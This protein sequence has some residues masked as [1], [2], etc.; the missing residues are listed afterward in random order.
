[1]NKTALNKQLEAIDLN[2]PAIR[3]ELRKSLAGFALIYLHHYFNLE[4]AD[5]HKELF[6]VIQNPKEEMI[7][8]TGFRGSA[9][10]TLTSFALPLWLALEGKHPFIILLSDS[11]TQM[12]MN[13]QNIKRELEDNP[14]ILADYGMQYSAKRNWSKGQLLLKNDVMLLG[15]ARGMKVRG[16]RW[17]QNRPS[18]LVGDDLESLDWVQKKENRDKT[19]RWFTSEVIPAVQED[20]SKI[21]V[22]GNLLHND[23]LMARLK[24]NKLF[25]CLDYPL[26]KNGACTWKAKYPT[27][28][29]LDRQKAKVGHA[30]WSREYLLKV[31]PEDRQIVKEHEISYYNTKILDE[32]T[33][34]GQAVVSINRA[35]TAFDLAI[36]EQNGSD[37]TAGISGLVGTM[38]GK[39][40]LFIKPDFCNLHLN[41]RDTI[42][43]AKR[44]HA[45][46]PYGA[47]LYVEDV[48]Y[49][50]A[51][52]QE[53]KNEGL[54]VRGIRPVKDKRARFESV[55]PYIQDGT[56]LFPNLEE[57]PEM[58]VLIDQMLGFGFEEFDD[59]LD[60]L[61]YL[62]MS[63]LSTP[64]STAI[65]GKV[66]RL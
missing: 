30:A 62:V 11:D 45:R 65:I 1:M 49:Q 40:H 39:K 42:A 59:L 63:M 52:L 5:F 56:V 58:R 27:Q 2:N 10:S 18:L 57:Y 32:V 26:I 17:R 14:L 6:R 47:E 34:D 35:G 21:V 60:A 15:R 61:V 54:P 3:A 50:K 20:K 16:L 25:R 24:K 66:N 29:A 19:E 53:M 41:F 38:S 9:K 23:A 12:Q 7:A 64:Q 44:M 48:A 8:I 37:F 22:V 31:L 55:A 28:E 36:G 33:S 13:V 43:Q 4:F 51:A 46:L